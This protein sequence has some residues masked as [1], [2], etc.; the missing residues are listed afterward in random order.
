MDF[1]E[2]NLDSEVIDEIRN[3]SRHANEIANKAIPFVANRDPF[4][5]KQVN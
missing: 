5:Y 1:K 4:Y 2:Q 3:L